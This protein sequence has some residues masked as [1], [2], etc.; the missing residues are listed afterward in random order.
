MKQLSQKLLDQNPFARGTLALALW[1]TAAC[2]PMP[3]A[4]EPAAKEP[5]APA[6]AEEEKPVLQ[7]NGDEPGWGLSVTKDKVSFLGDYGELRFDAPVE[8][9][10]PAKPDHYVA[11]K[12]G[13]TL[14]AKAT[15]EI[16]R[17]SMT[18]MPFPMTVSVTLGAKTYSGCGG[19]PAAFLTRKKWRDVAFVDGVLS[20]TLPS[21]VFQEGEGTPLIFEGPCGRQ[22]GSWRL[23]GEGLTLSPG[24]GRTSCSREDKASLAELDAILRRNARFDIA[25]DG[26]ILLIAGNMPVVRLAN[27]EVI[28]GQ[29]E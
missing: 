23:S 3:A 9:A 19:D 4:Q 20:G 8:P 14:V 12:D 16:C 24:R 17:S 6:K 22:V 15:K 7:A 26:S 27:P 18:G 29:K 1:C 28:N 11:R 2:G 10:D 5:A 21:V 13:Q 25:P